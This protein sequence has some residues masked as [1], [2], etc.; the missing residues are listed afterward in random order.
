MLVDINLVKSRLKRYVRIFFCIN[1]IKKNILLKGENMKSF[2]TKNIYLII[3]L[4]PILFYHIFFI[5]YLIYNI[6]YETFK[7]ISFI[8]YLIVLINFILLNTF[9]SFEINDE[10]EV[11]NIKIEK[12]INKE[13]FIKNIILLIIISMF[14]FSLSI[15]GIIVLICLQLLCMLIHPK[16]YTITD[17]IYLYIHKIYYTIAIKR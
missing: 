3:M 6:N 16:Q 10:F 2:I 11:L 15:L 7:I 1:L 8:S 17:V 9:L 13:V 12:K 4:Y 14:Y 5:C